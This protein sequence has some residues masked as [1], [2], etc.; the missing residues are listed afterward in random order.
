FPTRRSSDLITIVQGAFLPVPPLQGGA[1]EKAWYAL[2]REFAARGHRVTHVG[3]SYP[4]L[5]DEE[6][7]A[8]VCYRR[9]AGYAAPAQLWKLKPLDLLSPRRA[10]GV[11]PPADILVTN[12]FWLPLLERRRSR[13][14]IYVHV[15][16]YPKGQLRFYPRRA[17]LQ[18]VSAPVRDA[19]LAEVPGRREQVRVLPYPLAPAYLVERNDTPSRTVLRSEE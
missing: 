7:D 19:I 4:G 12:T 10:R 1:V 5:A 11:L 18:T 3:R 14:R 8:G 9:V 16:R 17:L 15:A 13:G 2:G 6:Q